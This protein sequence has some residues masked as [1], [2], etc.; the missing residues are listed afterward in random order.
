[1]RVWLYARKRYQVEAVSTR[2]ITRRSK[3]RSSADGVKI[4][5][6]FKVLCLAHCPPP[7]CFLHESVFVWME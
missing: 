4:L 3:L 1:M 5:F 2:M 6:R 7:L